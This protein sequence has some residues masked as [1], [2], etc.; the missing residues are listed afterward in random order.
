MSSVPRFVWW[1]IIVLIILAI[2]I[3]WAEHVTVHV[4]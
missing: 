3:L 2:M 4:H 1:L